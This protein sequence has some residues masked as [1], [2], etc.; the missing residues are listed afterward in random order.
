VRAPAPATPDLGAVFPS[1]A[2]E[3]RQRFEARR[4]HADRTVSGAQVAGGVLLLL[5]AGLLTWLNL[6]GTLVGLVAV[7]TLG[8]A[9]LMAFKSLVTADAVRH[10][11]VRVAPW[12]LDKLDEESLPI[13]TILVPLYREA[14]VVGRLLTS[15]RRLD[16]PRRKLQI[17]LLCEADDTPTLEA[18]YAANPGPPFEIV[19]VPPSYPRTKPKVCNVGLERA[20]GQYLVIYDAEDRPATDQLKKAVVAMRRLPRHVVCLQARLEYHNPQ[21]NLLTRFFAAEYGTFYDM[22]LPSLAR[23][24]LP[25]PLGGTSNHFRTSAL[26]ALGGWDSYN[27]TEDL[28]LGM[29]IARRRWRVEILDSI[30]WE[31]ANSRLGNWVRQRSR[32]LKGYMQTYLVH[33]RSPLRLWRD[34]GPGNFLAFQLL[35]GATPLTTLCN[36][37]LWGLTLAYAAT[38]SPLIQE[39]FP[40]PVFYLGIVSMVLGNFI[41]AYYLVTGCLLLGN[42]R[43]AKWMLAAPLYWMLMSVA[44]WK[45]A[46]Q[47]VV[48]P[49]YWEKT[50]HGLV[51]EELGEPVE[52]GGGWRPRPDPARVDRGG[53]RQPVGSPAAGREGA[54][55]AT[56]RG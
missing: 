49:H 38:G 32:W 10:G 28:D 8:Y 15:L 18:L 25:V 47:V 36:P 29:W 17:L 7:V 13:Y 48:R 16:Y 53:V 27:V 14:R 41:F 2:V 1:N 54:A 43:N 31:E 35:V 20:R 52:D 46:V 4:D 11:P 22:L 26:R 42:H 19:L 9:V 21:T 44:A 40:A 37:L 34:L 5:A 3:E 30:T 33:M 12:E 56:S 39:L 51:E 50:R 24:G 6:V 23:R 45:A 55:P